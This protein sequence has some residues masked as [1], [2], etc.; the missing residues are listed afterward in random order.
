MIEK[1]S[2]GAEEPEEEGDSGEHVLWDYRNDWEGPA[3]SCALECGCVPTYPLS[4]ERIWMP[5]IN[6]VCSSRKGRN[7]G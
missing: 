2:A 5:L 1:M 4:Q 3:R 6:S 7:F